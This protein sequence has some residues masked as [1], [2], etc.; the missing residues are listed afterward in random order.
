M[1]KTRD[2]GTGALYEIRG[3]K[4]WRGVL[5]L[6]LRP[7]GS[8]D[9]QY[10]HARTKKACTKKLEDLKTH[11]AAYGVPPGK[12]TTVAE[13]APHWLETVA[14][15]DVDPKTYSNYKSLLKVWIIPAIGRKKLSALTSSDVRAVRA[16]ILKER[17]TSQAK[18]AHTVISLMLDAAKADRLIRD[19]V[20]DDVR[21]VKLIQ[22]DREPLTT[23]QALRVLQVAAAMPD[24]AGSRW[25]FKLLAG[26]RQGEILG[27]TLAD[28]DLESRLYAVE[29]KLEELIRE[30]GCTED[31]R[32]PACGFKRGAACPQARWRVPDGFEKRQIKGRL[33]LTRPK[34]R[35]GRV[36]P[37]IP[38]LAEAIRRHIDATSH[39]PNPHGLIWRHPDGTPFL[40]AE[41]A[42]QWK[43]LLVE[44]GVIKPEEAKPG[45]TK[46]TGH[47]ARHTTVTILATLGVDT[48]VI[49]EIVGHSSE[50]ITQMYRKVLAK[51]KRA[52]MEAL[53]GVWAE[54][55][56]L[57]KEHP[58]PSV[59]LALVE[60]DGLQLDEDDDLRG[61]R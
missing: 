16:A 42:Q 18:Q 55:L 40:P 45:G 24:S 23:E 13:W 37:L 11:I 14:K 31:G 33:H 29:W 27:A 35:T 36:A 57:P 8:R 50:R 44:A 6:G 49:G 30:H 61:G 20:A 12:A 56:A 22:E 19:N 41:D 5:D 43:D 15:V 60:D 9:Q 25:W 32:P 4:L 34:S 47:V 52:A 2:H 59:E 17:S 53:G 7:D 38:Q 21:T 3:G 58:E 51:E 28:L 10:V 46:L 26:Q 1:P 48:R 39:W 54:G